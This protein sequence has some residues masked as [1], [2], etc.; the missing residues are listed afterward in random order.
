M[1]HNNDGSFTFELKGKPVKKCSE[2]KEEQI[3]RLLNKLRITKEKYEKE[4]ISI[5]EEIKNV[6]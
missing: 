5:E 1:Q 2:N 4:L 6:K 3:K